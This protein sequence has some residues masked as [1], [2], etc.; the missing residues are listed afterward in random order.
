MRVERGRLRDS[1]GGGRGKVKM[2]DALAMESSPWRDAAIQK[3]WSDEGVYAQL[4]LL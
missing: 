1:R 3:A 2:A 4:A